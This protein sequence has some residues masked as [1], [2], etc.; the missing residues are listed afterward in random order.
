[1]GA[2]RFK[3]LQEYVREHQREEYEYILRIVNGKA[4][5]F[6]GTYGHDG[7]FLPIDEAFELQ[8]AQK[9]EA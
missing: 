6:V 2:N 3:N 8:A 4:V 9:E 5:W 7:E 1:M